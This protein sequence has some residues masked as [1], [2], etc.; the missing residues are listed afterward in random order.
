[1]FLKPTVTITVVESS[2][3]LSRRRQQNISSPAIDLAR[4]QRAVALE[5]KKHL[6]RAAGQRGFQSRVLVDRPRPAIVPNRCAPYT[7]V[8]TGSA[9]GNRRNSSSFSRRPAV[10]VPQ[11]IQFA[12]RYLFRKMALFAS[13]MASNSVRPY[14]FGSISEY[15][16]LL[17]SVECHV[18]SPAMASAPSNVA[19]RRTVTFPMSLRLLEYPQTVSICRRRVKHKFLYAV[20]NTEVM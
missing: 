5:A 1:M 12:L 16:P 3:Q 20:E 19:S 14:S 9:T 6:F 11:T 17:G 8:P 13:T 18:M 15:G 4:V 2:T 10:V 7:M